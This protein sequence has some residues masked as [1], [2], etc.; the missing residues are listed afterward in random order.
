[1][2]KVKIYLKSKKRPLILFIDDIELVKKF[3]ALFENENRYV[4]FKNFI[5]D[6]ND[7]KCAIYSKS[8]KI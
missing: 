2:Y 4:N 5:I 1:M 6:K 3:Y 7:F 8:K